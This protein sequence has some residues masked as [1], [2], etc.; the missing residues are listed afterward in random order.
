MYQTEKM[1]ITRTMEKDLIFFSTDG[2]TSRANHSY[3]THTVHYINESWK[4][5]SHLLDTAELSS[6]HTGVNLASELEESL[7]QL[8]LEVSKLV[9]V[10]TENAIEILEWQQFGCFAHTLQLGVIKVMDVPQISKALGRA[11]CL[12]SDSSKSSSILRQ[13]QTDLHYSQLNLVQ[14]VTTWWNSS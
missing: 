11:K 9:T 14:D 6:E 10:T 7:Q 4:F 8:N 12:V 1:K 3:I 5:C 13:E 2:W